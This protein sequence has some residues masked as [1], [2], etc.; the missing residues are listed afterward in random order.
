MFVN[1]KIISLRAVLLGLMLALMVTGS[2]F[3]QALNTA[4]VEGVVRDADTGQP[5]AGVQVM[6]FGT[7]LGNVTNS[8][9]YFFVLNVPPGQR[10]V[11]F[12]YTGYQ[13]TTVANQLL[14][15]G[16]TMTVD[17]NLSSTVVQLEGIVIE[18][19]REVL[20]PRDNTASKQRLTGEKLMEA[21]ATRLEDLMVLEAGVAL[22]GEGGKARGLR[23][24]GGRLGE[25]AMV[26]D[27][28]TVRNYT[29]DPYRTGQFWI[30]TQEEASLSEDTTPLEFSTSAVE[31]VDI[32]TGGFQ[33]EY[34]NAQSGIVNIVTKEG[35][36]DLRGNIRWTSDEGNP[37][38]SDYGYNQ[39]TTSVGGPVPFIPHLN[40]H[41]SGELQGVED[42]SPTHASEGFRGVNQEYVDRLNWAVRNDPVYGDPEWW[43]GAG[44]DEARPAFTLDEMAYGREVWADR[45]GEEFF[46]GHP[47]VSEGLFTP[48]HP[49]R[50]PGNWQDRNL[51]NA[52]L[53][54]SPI[55][56]LKFIVT[57]NFSRNQR[58]WPAESD[59]YW[60][61]G[62][63]DPEMLTSRMWST[64]KG[65]IISGPDTF[66]YQEVGLGRRTRTGQF[67][68]GVNWDFYQSAERSASLQFRFMNLR[69]Q[70]IN[71]SNIKTNW[72]RD[73]QFLTFN[74]HDLPFLVETFPG[75]DHLNNPEDA[76][77]Y[78]P[79][80]S[81]VW[82]RDHTYWTPFGYATDAQL[83]Y[84]NYRYLREDQN[85]FKMDLDLQ[86]NRFNR[87]KLGWQGT[88]FNNNQFQVRTQPR[89]LDNEFDYRPR[90]YSAYVQNRT[91][92]GDFVF[93]YGIRWDQFQPRDN[94]GFRNNDQY[95][96]RYFPDNQ[97]EISPRF[98]VGFPITDKTQ[99]RFSYGVFT[100]LPSYTF[101]FSGQNPGGLGYAR[102]DAFEA[103]LSYLL[104]D[105]VVLDFTGFY[106]D[107]DGN[108]SSGSFFRDYTQ[109]VTDRWVRGI[110]NAFTNSDRSN[111]KG[112]DATMRKRFSDHYSLNLIYTMQFARTTGSS[113]QASTNDELRP[114]REDRT[115][116]LSAHFSY[117]TDEDVFTG[118]WANKVF[119]N[120]RGYLMPS[121]MSGKPTGVFV[122]IQNEYGSLNRKR[123]RWTYNVD[124]RLS[125][126]FNLSGRNR[127]SLFTEIYNLTNRKLP[128]P[129]PSGYS[130]Q[131]HRYKT[132][133]V[134]YEWETAP[135]ES[136]WLFVRDFDGDG[137]LTIDEVARGSI[138]DQFARDTDNFT[139]WGLARQIRTGIEFTF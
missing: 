49:S 47:W 71:S 55:R 42:V 23:I 81:G 73:T 69:V 65:D 102:T 57:E 53:T 76:A 138:A 87:M 4:K 30:Y 62:W 26:V 139:A 43:I 90:L 70:D 88:Y 50:I 89:I 41:L 1:G 133:G 86:L 125:K 119:K 93:D 10:N 66:A 117:M 99:M 24:R 72:Q 2:A 135:S 13:K 116:K 9:G 97:S 106:R 6:I 67:L 94:W 110:Q 46:S 75:R 27:G 38:T 126:E 7:Q 17:C 44:Y 134:E 91:D 127:I 121:V 25:E 34:G 92:L 96:E 129:Y 111:V 120:F 84:L 104:S 122:N 12:S 21:P 54:Y 109:S 108:V 52:K 16:Q 78:Y 61:D 130:F 79:D 95:G 98:N 83:Y 51:L 115:H 64:L 128:Q 112:F 82:N 28:V 18:G 100:Q 103:G 3:A 132:G 29:A 31:E 22:G 19:E 80:G 113:Y 8:D 124:L 77:W 58:Q 107:A 68:A 33:A 5:L 37:R 118:T 15:A 74:M 136:K 85:T 40:F 105:E 59:A 123:G 20:I 131:G 36:P 63:V 101:I 32:I 48:K 39:L 56:G 35:G 11:V 60:R 14:L 114:S 137:V 45:M